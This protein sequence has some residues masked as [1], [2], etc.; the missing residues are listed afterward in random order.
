MGTP[1]HS[2][3]GS[4]PGTG[5]PPSPASP[6]TLPA[7]QS[8]F[9]TATAPTIP[10]ETVLGTSRPTSDGLVGCVLGDFRVGT[11]LGRGGMGAVY[12]GRQESLDRD[13]AIKVLPPHL[14]DN[15]G[16]RSRFQLEAKAVA[17]LD[18]PHIIKVYGAGEAHGHHWFAMEYVE[19]HDLA[20][21]VRREGRPSRQTALGWVLQAARGLQAAGDLGIIHRDIKPA[22]MMLTKRG[23][24]KIMDFGLVRTTKEA[25]GLTMTG[26]VMGTVSYF[27]P[28]QGRGERC[29]C[30]TDLYALGVMFYEFLTGRLPFTG[31]DPTSIIYQHIHVAPTPPREVDPTIPEDFQS[32]VL[33]CLQK[34]AEDR[35][36]TAAELVADLERLTRGDHPDINPAEKARLLQGTTLYLPGKR[37]GRRLA[38][39]ILAGTSVTIAAATSVWL[40]KTSPTPTPAAPILAA[41]QAPIAPNPQPVPTPTA[42]ALVVAPP[43][44]LP[45]QPQQPA[46]QPAPQPTPQ[47][48]APATVA[49][50]AKPVPPVTVDPVAIPAVTQPV[51]P[52][53]ETAVIAA[54]AVTLTKRIQELA[55][56][57]QYAEARTLL[58][59]ERTA[60][61]TN[62]ELAPLSATID[63]AEG[64]T[65]VARSRSLVA[66]GDLAGAAE[67]LHKAHQLLGN[68][69]EVTAATEERRKRIADVEHLAAEATSLALSGHGDEALA[70]LGKA[71]QL[72]PAWPAVT[73]A[74]TA[75]RAELA[76]QIAARAKR[77]AALTAGAA[78]FAAGDLAAADLAYAQA[79]E[80]EPENLAA[81]T[82][83]QQVAERQQAI[84]RQRQL[85]AT[86]ITAKDLPGA[87]RALATLTALVPAAAATSSTAEV[88]GLKARLAEEARLAAELEAKR[89]AWGARIIATAKDPAAS[90]PAVEKDLAAFVADTGGK[91]PEQPALDAAVDDRRQREAV[92]SRLLDLD[93]A[94]LAGDAQTINAI[95]TDA[96]HATAL[97]GLAK[98]Q[99]LV[100]VTSLTGFTRTGERGT[101][102]LK[103]RNGFATFPETTLPYRCE[104]ARTAAGW[105]ITA[106]HPEP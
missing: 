18:S 64:A 37:P 11:L 98:Q 102:T 44:E 91:R 69:P 70:S 41:S 66:R 39:W 94:V 81:A 60:Q 100:F 36:Q 62:P 6:Q 31:E 52:A 53:Q 85:L 27:S 12:R 4:Q 16:F 68:T 23:M 22:N 7:T 24:V 90:F 77:D 26:T 61:P 95:V 49:V 59:S 65:W 2:P 71:Q 93:R 13:V 10:A 58:A 50:Q 55:A 35:Y 48:V 67:P 29:D 74:E 56:N 14:S 3:P 43:P 40:A 5:L 86:A 54:G 1:P 32:V 92:I 83:R 34:R 105:T 57:S 79:Q 73:T 51:V 72:A 75:I 106:A 25:Q 88:A 42:P 89:V 76:R 80:V 99:D 63:R 45:N 47:I 19:G 78:A 84:A 33:K 96:A 82:G 87:E 28:E 15:E 97:A 101:A 9:A 46:P 8:G 38:P 21:T 103:L 30:R 20:Q 104:L 17:S